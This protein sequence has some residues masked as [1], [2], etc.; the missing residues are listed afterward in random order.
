MNL[1]TE[2]A[3]QV[4][5]SRAYLSTLSLAGCDPTQSAENECIPS[6]WS[7]SSDPELDG[8]P[9]LR[10]AVLCAG[11]SLGLDTRREGKQRVW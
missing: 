1:E 11:E 2:A 8:G 7:S 9:R 4:C 5:T 10:H 3:E 6:E